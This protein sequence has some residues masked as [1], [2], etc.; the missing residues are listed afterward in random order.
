MTRQTNV[1]RLL[2]VLIL[3]VIVL[4]S[5]LL[6]VVSLDSARAW[7]ELAHLQLPIFVAVV[8]GLVPV[9]VALGLVLDFLGVVDRGDAFSTRTVQIL[10][11]L[12][13]LIG[14]FGLYVALGLV[15]AWA[16]MRLM[17]PTL[18]FLWFMVEVAALFLFTVVAVL[19]RI[20]ADALALRQD[21]EL[22][23]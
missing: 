11:R 20:F 1:L 21:N 18:V 10:W 6:Y 13:V 3:V 9:V 19:E 23:V 17:H 16:A 8:V 12:R 22:T 14:A 4:A 15:G 2:L 7:P 5:G